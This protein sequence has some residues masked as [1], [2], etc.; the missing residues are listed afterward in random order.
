MR[1]A[2]IVLVAIIA[3]EVGKGNKGLAGVEEKESDWGAA[4]NSCMHKDERGGPGRCEKDACR[5]PTV[6]RHSCW[7]WM[8]PGRGCGG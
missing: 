8:G 6:L 7:M 5:F 3:L 1:D 2:N 4:T